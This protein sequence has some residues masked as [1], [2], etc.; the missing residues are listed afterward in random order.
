M[1]QIHQNK[2]EDEQFDCSLKTIFTNVIATQLPNI[3]KSGEVLYWDLLESPMGSMLTIANNNNLYFLEFAEKN[4]LEKKIKHL[5]TVT[6]A[7][8]IYGRTAITDLIEQE[9]ADYFAGEITNFKTPIRMLGSAF[10]QASWQE[11]SKVPYGETISYMG[12]AE[13]VGS[14]SAYR[15]VAN[16]NAA[17]RLAIIIPCHRVINNNGK[18][19]GYGGGLWR[20]KWL[21]EH[22]QSF[23]NKR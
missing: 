7:S 12:Q 4:R 5:R 23:K 21:L 18:L 13:G 20:K 11:L 6:R 3:K 16:A 17:N 14:T 22:E 1:A 8:I 2:I 10:Q 9:L 15:A 19:G